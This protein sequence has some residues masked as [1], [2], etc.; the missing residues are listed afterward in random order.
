MRSFYKALLVSAPVAGLVAC[1]G[2]GPSAPTR[3]P[4]HTVTVVVYYDQDGNNVL[5]GADPVRIP[6]ATVSMGGVS[7]RTDATGRATIVG[8]PEGLQTMTV[9]AESLPPYY[10]V[11]PLSLGVPTNGEVRLPALLPIS[12]RMVRNKYMGFGDSL[13]FGTYEEPLE[14]QLRGYFGLGSVVDE[15]LSGTRSDKGAQRIGDAL[16]YARPAHT[17]ILYGTNDWNDR[18]CKEDT[19]PCFTI[20]SLRTMIKEAKFVG[21][22]PYLATLPPVNVGFNFQAPPEREEWTQR[23]NDLIRK[24][25]RDEGVVLV[26]LH[27]V[28]SAAPNRASLY[29]DYVH[30][31]RQGQNL[32]AQ[33]FFKSLT[34]RQAAGAASLPYILNFSAAH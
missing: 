13:S 10:T 1:G 5:D 7:G 9:S 17:L 30:P 12:P 3:I 31:N 8:V 25:A 4:T 23:M 32:I 19:F 2:S 14:A 16:D 24:L 29:D 28:M 26:D 6:N 34:Q 11:A 22:L 27:K 18:A 33:E 15:G 20:D 21:S